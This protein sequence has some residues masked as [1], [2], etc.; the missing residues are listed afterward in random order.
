MIK[1]L[2]SLRFFFAFF[3]FLSH[4][5]Y[6][7]KE[8]VFFN[9]IYKDI[10]RH[11]S[12]GVSFFF[13]LSGFILA[14]NY[15][16]RIITK[17]V[18]FKDFWAARIARIYPLHLF[19]LLLSLPIFFTEY[20]KAP[21]LWIG[22][23]LANLLLLQSFVPEEE[24]YF[25]FNAVSWSISN[26]LFYYM[27][28]PFLILGFYKF[29][30]S[31]YLSLLLLLAIPLGIYLS[32]THIEVFVFGINPLLRISDFI[33]GI[34]LFKIYESQ[35][36]KSWFKKFAHAT[37]M[38]LAALA[39]FILFFCFRET[40]AGGYR[41]SSYYWIPMCLIVLVHSY[42][43]GLISKILSHKSLIW[44]GEISFSFYMLHGLVM[45]YLLAA[46][47][48]LQ[49]VQH[50]YIM[51][52]ILFLA[53]ILA[54]FLVYRTVE[55]SANRYLRNLYR[56]KQEARANDLLTEELEVEKIPRLT[57]TEK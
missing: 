29:P 9:N 35:I 3:V 7:P 46:E 43:N 55:L 42:Q 54:S 14:Y 20:F 50:H 32:P 25:G 31:I 22:S 26:E 19:T 4:L 24:I 41:L 48:R 5:D 27:A 53:T 40:V 13:I 6:L 16:N 37:L 12:L 1:P 38:E 21:L 2:T 17:E 30:R 10:L 47:R 39:I 51:M 18:S 44:L 33:I 15:K 11:G 34:L 49:I 36:I 28:F 52:T 56:R 57:E 8:E 23:F 45:R